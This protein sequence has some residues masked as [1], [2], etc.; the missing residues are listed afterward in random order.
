VTAKGD[1]W[2]EVKADGAAKAERY[3]AQWRGGLPKSGGGPDKEIVAAIAKA[4]VGDRVTVKWTSDE[5]KRVIGLSVQQAVSRPGEGAGGTVTGA[6]TAKGENWVE[7]KADGAE[8][9]ERYIPRRTGPNSD[10]EV[11]AQIAKVKVGD[12][13]NLKWTFQEHKRVLSITVVP[14]AP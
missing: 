7:V 4:K 8:K 2:I 3:T 13:V 6:V 10:K 14:P 5:R 1:A 11:L 9:A 12:K